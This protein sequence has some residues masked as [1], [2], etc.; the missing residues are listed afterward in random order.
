MRSE[1]VLPQPEGPTSTKNSPSRISKLRSE[2]TALPS[3]SFHTRS[4]RIWFTKSSPFVDLAEHVSRGREPSY[5]GAS[6]LPSHNVRGPGQPFRYES[7]TAPQPAPA[8]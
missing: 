2:T 3:K 6:S 4:K 1:V 8:A 5:Y 7:D